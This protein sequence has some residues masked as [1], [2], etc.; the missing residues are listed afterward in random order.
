MGS[1]RNAALVCVIVSGS[2]SGCG[3]SIDSPVSSESS[4]T[5]GVATSQSNPCRPSCSIGEGANLF[6]SVRD[7]VAT[8]RTI[9]FAQLVGKPMDSVRVVLE[10]TS[11]DVVSESDSVDLVVNSTKILPFVVGDTSIAA[12]VL[13]AP[14]DKRASAF[15]LLLSTDAYLIRSARTASVLLN[16]PNDVSLS[17]SGTNC[18]LTTRQGTCGTTGWAISPFEPGNPLGS[19]QSAMGTGASAEIT[20]SFTVPIT[21]V[22]ITAYDPT[23]VGNRMRATGSSGTQSVAFAGSGTPGVQVPSTKTLTGEFTSVTLTPAEGDYV[24]YSGNITVGAQAVEISCTPANPSRGDVVDCKTTMSTPVPYVVVRRTA[25]GEKY[26]VEDRTRTAYAA[27]E[28]DSWSGEAVVTAGIV[29]EVELQSGGSTVRLKNVA[30]AGYTVQPR[31]W[32]AWQLTTLRQ[33]TVQ[34]VPGMTESILP[35]TTLGV[36]S[37]DDPNV[38]TPDVKRAIA[39]PNT[40]FA[41][42]LN[43]IAVSS[44]E[45]AVNPGIVPPGP[46]T[47]AGS[48]TWYNDQNGLGS[49]TCLA[50]D[51]ATLLS[52][53]DRHEGVTQAANSHFGVANT[54]FSLLRPDRL[55]EKLVTQGSDT[56]LR[57]LVEKTFSDFKTK[58]AYRA[59]QRQFD[60][61]DTPIV[62]AIGCTLD[63]NPNDQ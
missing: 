11:P 37:V 25:K 58:G 4:K 9:G 39:G 28:S 12:V 14:S 47:P 46:S 50:P 13:V 54:Q 38:L 17:V 49:G 31:S 51:L 8:Q 44:Y 53:V 3:V 15:R 24:A 45:V 62:N 63:L 42:L 60:A 32:P 34:I 57:A 1:P 43:P 5:S 26:K 10:L 21:S 20:I 52:S 22:T 6:A 16:V 7:S 29:V 19:F 18:D 41:F 35:G 40:G 2:L 61:V 55:L 23:F 36:F 27:G 56:Q 48:V 59:A 33:R 30:S